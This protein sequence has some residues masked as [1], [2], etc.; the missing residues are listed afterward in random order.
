MH[1]DQNKSARLQN[2]T[3]FDAARRPAGRLPCQLGANIYERLRT[4]E[5]KIIAT[6]IES[7]TA[8]SKTKHSINTFASMASPI[9]PCPLG[10]GP[11]VLKK[12]HEDPRPLSLSLSNAL[13]TLGFVVDMRSI[14]MTMQVERPEARGHRPSQV[15]YSGSRV[16]IT[17]YWVRQVRRALAKGP[18]SFRSSWPWQFLQPQPRNPCSQTRRLAHLRCGRDL[19]IS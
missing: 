5:L 9:Q 11:G 2:G 15:L 18:S 10:A 17:S 7:R 14:I 8:C 16:A 13:W 3:P 1:D 12:K 6:Q 19:L 4:A